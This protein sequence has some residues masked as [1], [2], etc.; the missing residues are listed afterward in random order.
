MAIKATGQIT[1][2]DLSDSRQLSCYFA[3]NVPKV[4]IYDP[5][6]NT[7]Q[8]NWTNT[9]VILTPSLFLNQ[10]GL[11]L[12]SS[13][14]TIEWKRKEGTGSETALTTGETVSNGKLTIKQNKLSSVSSGLLTYVCY[15]T[16]LD[17][18]TDNTINISADLAF[19]LIKNAS[20]AKT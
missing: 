20:A 6:A 1:L 16:Y 9:N 8:P 15:V 10:T 17:P 11:P 18:E 14:L 13:G 5:D 19:S 12:T 2:V 3:C 7:Y 4:Q